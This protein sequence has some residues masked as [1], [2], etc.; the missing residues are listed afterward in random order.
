MNNPFLEKIDTKDK[1]DIIGSKLRSGIEGGS[2]GIE[3]FVP[4]ISSTEQ[5]YLEIITSERYEE[6]VNNLENLTGE[7]LTG[8]SIPRLFS[9]LVATVEQIQEV[10][11][12]YR[13]ELE[14]LA[15]DT[16]L[17]L[18]EFQYINQL[19]E[20]GDIKINIKLTP[21]IIKFNTDGSEKEEEGLDDEEEL[22]MGLFDELEDMTDESYK[23]LFANTLIQGNAQS[24]A[25]LYY[26]LKER[27]DEIDPTLVDKYNM[28]LAVGDLMFFL[29]PPSSPDNVQLAGKE[30]L[31]AE[32]DIYTINVEA[33]TLPIL[34]HEL[35][36]GLMEYIHYSS[37]PQDEGER[38]TAINQADKFSNEQLGLTIG[39]KL[40]AALRKYFSFDELKYLPRVQQLLLQLPPDNIKEVFASNN[41]SA[42][43]VAHLKKQAKEEFDSF[44]QDQDKYQDGYQDQDQDGDDG[45]SLFS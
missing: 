18:P 5:K 15:Y 7:K 4:D 23:R 22:N 24:K 28:L 37:L 43:I 39:T 40:D 31:K 35:T 30:E 17:S 1:F 8:G 42:N 29:D 38:R 9:G 16:V 32:G 25:K 44:E 27:L 45:L 14:A 41:K 12:D 33:G 3:K 2:T 21:D 20:E 34:I 26:M 10:E 11:Q 13:T 19:I 6:L 36:K